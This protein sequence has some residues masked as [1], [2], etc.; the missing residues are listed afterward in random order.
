MLVCY[1]VSKCQ[2]G[3][4]GCSDFCHEDRKGEVVCSCPANMIVGSDQKTCKTSC[5]I[6][7]AG[8]SHFCNDTD[9]GAVCDCPPNLKLGS[10]N[11][12]C[13]VN[14]N[15][16]KTVPNLCSSNASCINTFGSY[17][18][19]CKPGFNGDGQQCV[20]EKWSDPSTKRCLCRVRAE[21]SET[22]IGPILYEFPTLIYGFSNVWVEEANASS[23]VPVTDRYPGF[24]STRRRRQLTIPDLYTCLKVLRECP[25]DCE[26][27]SKLTLGDAGLGKKFSVQNSAGVDAKKTLGQ[28]SCERFGHDIAPPGKRVVTFYKPPRA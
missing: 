7:N 16:C 27:L 20:V 24:Y 15:E 21:I 19:E 3:N 28:I 17:K 10:N 18:C 12:L 1:S 13:D 25:A 11:K 4:G 2:I 14:V 9:H 5:T 22:S 26:R 6:N 23:P 8:C